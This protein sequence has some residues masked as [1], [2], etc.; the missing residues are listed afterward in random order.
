METTTIVQ[1]NV[2]GT[3]TGNPYTGKFKVKTLLTRRDAFAA[4]ER[5]RV[6]IGANPSAVSPSTSAEAFMISQLSVRVLDAPK[7][8]GDSDSG[9]DLEDDN[10][11]SEIFTLV[12][13]AE[14]ERKDSLKK[15]SKKAVKRMS[16]EVAS[17][18]NEG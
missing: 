8:W 17:D 3:E 5:R 16:A 11:I 10:V 9:L 4:D 6:L 7:W 15:E 12:M 1:V 13:K 14:D 18:D 2:I